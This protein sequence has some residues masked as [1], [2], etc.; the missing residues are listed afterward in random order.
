MFFKKV[1]ET[2]PIRPNIGLEDL[3]SQ[4]IDWLRLPLALAVVFIHS[5]GSPSDYNL[6]D[7]HANPLDGMSVYNLVRICFSH[8]LSHIAVPTFFLISGFLFFYKV[9]IWNK[10]TYFGKMKSRLK[11][12]V[13]PYLCWN[14]IAIASVVAI[15]IAALFFKDRPLNSVYTLFENNGWLHMLWD[16]HVWA[17]DRTNYLGWATPMTGPYNLPLWFLR[18]LIVV[19]AITPLIYWFIKRTQHYGLLLLA[20]SYISGVFPDIHGLNITAVFFFSAG[21]YFSIFG[22][23]LVEQFS[24]VKTLSYF[25]AVAFLLP[26]IWFDGRNTG[27]GYIIY[28]FYI[29]SGVCAIFNL[30]THLLKRGATK[31]YPTLSQSTFFIYATHTILILTISSYTANLLISGDSLIAL[32]AKYFI[33]PILATTICICLYLAMRRFLPKITKVL[34][35][36]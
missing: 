9:N 25:T 22:K 17:E 18:D 24:K 2:N 12:L 13:V 8:V 31:V 27:I 7:I 19:T 1:P 32:T 15:Q 28:P 10:S 6:A 29:I 35:G 5:F 3:Q 30:A 4:T 11:S 34:M 14:I 16:C 26:C 36:R 33:K 21:A 23:N 20:A